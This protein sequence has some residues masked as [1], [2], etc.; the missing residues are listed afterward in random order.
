MTFVQQ[1]SE[2]IIS[3]KENPALCINSKTYSYN[4]FAQKIST[5]R[6]TIAIEIPEHEKLIG[7]ITNDDIETYA[8]IIALWLEGKAY[9]SL[10]PTAP[11]NRNQKILNSTSSKFILSSK[12]VDFEYNCT[13]IQTIALSGA[14]HINLTPKQINQNNIAY[15]IFTSGST[16]EPKG[17]PIT[18]AN[19][20]GFVSNIENSGDFKLE[21]TDRCLQMFELSF[22]MSVVSYLLPFLSGACIYTI[23]KDAI[24]YFYIF[25]LLQE[26]KLTVLTLVASVINY[27]RPYFKEIHIAEVRYC[28]FAGGALYNDIAVEWNS[29]IPNCQILNYYGPTETTI[30]SGYYKFDAKGNNKTNNDIVSI[31]RPFKDL[32]YIIVNDND[33]LVEQGTDGE[34]CISGSHVMP[35]YWKDSERDKKVFITKTHNGVEKK[36]YKTGDL[37]L[38]DVDG[39]YLFVGR[40]D[41]QVKIRGYR[42][43]LA[44]VEFYAK[45]Y[46]Q[47]KVDL[48]VVDILNNLEN[49]ELLMCIESDEFETKTIIANMKKE[50]PDYMIPTEVFFIEKFPLNMN[51]K[52]DRTKLRL[53]LNK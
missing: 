35:G 42:V 48:V 50:L 51:G 28:S 29:C 21:P 10:N 39:D 6:N 53:A 36:F 34:L 9:V 13:T 15:I 14:E 32:D 19:V 8:S 20:Q 46:L 26:Q 31:G 30:Y 12:S 7:L 38:E 4:E 47:K 25:K 24:K 37:C 2:S 43:E 52:I 22:D 41:F 18:F 27:L 45:K 33:D 40:V 1:L 49:A 5:I 11:K 17:V 16:G 44:E 3:F 23:P